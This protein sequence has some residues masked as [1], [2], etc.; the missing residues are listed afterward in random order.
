MSNGISKGVAIDNN[1]T[2]PI[3]L[4][5]IGPAAV[6]DKSDACSK[7]L[8]A[9]LESAE[10]WNFDVKYVGPEDEAEMSVKEGL[11]LPDAVLYAQPGGDN[12]EVDA[13]KYLEECAPDVRKFVHDGGRYFATCMGAYF[14]G[15]SDKFPGFNFDLKVDQYIDTPDAPVK[16]DRD[17]IVQ[18]N[19]NIQ[20]GPQAGQ[21]ITRWMYFQDGPYFMPENGKSDQIILAKYYKTDYI[22]AMVKPY[23]NGWIGVCGPHPEADESWYKDKDNCIIDPDG[24]DADLGRD[25]INTLMMQKKRS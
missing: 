22:A 17:T 14:A 12:N 16:D 9:L 3:A 5:Y 19:W 6:C 25:L 20:T 8:A 2:K 11:Q 21:T 10:Q 23:G 7:A 4:V 1:G 24:F 15:N 13:F 18:V